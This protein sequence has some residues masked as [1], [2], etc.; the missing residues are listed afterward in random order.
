MEIV[1]DN[2]FK[3]KE[4][5]FKSGNIISIQSNDI[6]NIFENLVID[7]NF[8]C[9]DNNNLFFVGNTVIDEFDIYSPDFDSLFLYAILE[10]LEFDDIF[11]KKKISNLSYV[12]KLY[13]NIIRI[14]LL[15]N[16]RVIFNNIFSLMDNYNQKKL[17]NLLS[18]LKDKDYYLVISN[19]NVNFLYKY[20][21]YSVVWNKKFFDFDIVDNVYNN[22][23]PL[24]KN[25][26]SVPILPL[27]TYKA[28]V[29]KDV[30][31][32]YSKDVRDIIKDIYKHV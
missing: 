30:R 29:E 28:K 24:I 20:A 3:K 5:D 7:Y 31:L 32:F 26:F 11:L 15:G 4:V 1:L 12:E 17:I 18:Y 14:L 8:D 27:I 25:K 13:V 9:V 6:K 21:D 16:K 2:G 22:V 23:E 19:K 10:V